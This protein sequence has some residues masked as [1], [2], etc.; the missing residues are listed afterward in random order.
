MNHFFQKFISDSYFFPDVSKMKFC[1]A[2]NTGGIF[3]TLMLNAQFDF[4]RLD[5]LI[6]LSFVM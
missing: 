3:I 1:Y 2:L 5:I 6:V 4:E